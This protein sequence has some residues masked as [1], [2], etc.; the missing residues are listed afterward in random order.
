M[1]KILFLKVL[2]IGGDINALSL[3]DKCSGA[4]CC[5]FKLWQAN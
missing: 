1:F 2:V 5:G 4:V 3:D